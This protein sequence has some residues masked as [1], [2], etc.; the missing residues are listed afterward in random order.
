[1]PRIARVVCS[2]TPYHVTQRGNYRQ[3]IFEEEADREKYM[4]FFIFYKEKYKLKL[5]AW[6]LMSNHVHFVVEPSTEDGLAKVFNNTN[7]R[8]SQYFNRKRGLAGHLF[9]GRFFSC[10]LDSDH[11]YEAMRYVEL[12]P[13]RAGVSSR[14]DAYKWS[15]ARKHLT[16]KG[17][18]VL[19]DV[20][21]HLEIDNWRAYLKEKMDEEIVKRIRANTKTGRP[22]GDDKFVQKIEKKTG[23]NF[24][25]KKVGRPKKK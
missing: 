18:I 21:K 8:Y 16:G 23:M 2:D 14:P 25:F 10:V 1:M 6:C 19:N 15:S 22:A 17:D 3:D 12:N 9:Q 4:E 13:L 24:N 7:M 5:Y 11:L 20:S